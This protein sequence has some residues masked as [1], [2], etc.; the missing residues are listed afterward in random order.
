MTDT[1]AG[2]FPPVSRDQWLDEVR[3]VLLKGKPDVTD[4]DFL[5]AFDSRLVSRTDDG[6]EIQPLYTADD[7]PASLPEAGQAP[8]PPLDACG[9]YSVGDPTARV[10][11]RAR[12]VGGHGAGVRH[13]RHSRDDHRYRSRC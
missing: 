2:D 6:I 12:L 8:L 3:R 4:V 11:F 1:L 5:K 10:A 7:A 9:S 13:H